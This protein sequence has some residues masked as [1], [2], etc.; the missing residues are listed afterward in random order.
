MNKL[1]SLCLIWL[2]G[3]LT[4][5]CTLHNPNGSHGK[6]STTNND[7]ADA[8]AQ[9]VF[10]QLIDAADLA[11][12][13]EDR[14]TMADFIAKVARPAQAIG[15]GFELKSAAY[16]LFAGK[17][18]L[19]RQSLKNLQPSYAQNA[20]QFDTCIGASLALVANLAGNELIDATAKCMQNGVGSNR[21]TEF[22]AQV[23]AQVFKHLNDTCGQSCIMHLQAK[24]LSPSKS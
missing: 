10:A 17:D 13:Q 7:P 12:G 16:Q 9:L 24:L 1:T 18:D 15:Q 5:S 21:E 6:S 22:M 23:N 11:F 8:A 2:A 20:G 3:C 14:L 4:V 19:A